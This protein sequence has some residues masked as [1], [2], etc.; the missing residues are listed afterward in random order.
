MNTKIISA[1]ALSAVLAAPS[2][3]FAQSA[4]S[5]PS[6]NAPVTRASIRTELV[7]LERAGYNPGLNDVNYPENLQAAEHRV[8]AENATSVGGTTAGSTASGQ[9]AQ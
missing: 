1:I 9:A 3:A 8:Q 4:Q 6:A 7:S 2:F 5:A